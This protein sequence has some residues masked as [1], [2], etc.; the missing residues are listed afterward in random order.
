MN[1]LESGSLLQN[2]RYKVIKVLGQGGFGVTYLA[3]QEIFG[4]QVAIKEFFM[5][6]YCN[7]ESGTQRVVVPTITTRDQVIRFK[8]KFIKEA[9]HIAGLSHPNIVHVID[10]FEENDTA[11]YVMEYLSGGTL[12]EYV[13]KN[14][15]LPEV[16]AVNYIRQIASALG[17]VHAHQLLHLD[18]KPAN[19]MLDDNGHAVLV[20]FGVSKRYDESGS[21][22]SS[23]PLGVS[24]GYAPIEQYEKTSLINFSPSTDIYSLGASLFFLLTGNHPPTASIL[25][26]EGGLSLPPNIS[27][28]L[29]ECIKQCMAPSRKARPQNIEQ[30]MQLLE[31]KPLTTNKSFKKRPSTQKNY[32]KIKTYNELLGYFLKKKRWIVFASSGLVF[33]LVFIFYFV[34]VSKEETTDLGNVKAVEEPVVTLKVTDDSA[35]TKEFAVDGISFEMRYVK[36]GSFMMGATEEQGKET[37]KTEKPVH[38]VIL[39]DFFIAK[40]EVTQELWEAVMGNN[41]SAFKDNKKPVENVSWTDC[42]N[43]IVKLNSLTG[44]NFSLPTEAQWE[45]A[46][47]GGINTKK[48]RYAGDNDLFLVGWCKT[49]S[50]GSTQNVGSMRPNELGLYDM[51]GNVCEWCLDWFDSYSKKNQKNP[52]GPETGKYKVTRGGSWHNSYYVCRISVRTFAGIETK[53]SNLGFRLVLNP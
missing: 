26:S 30:F 43:F 11:Y 42:Q 44:M 22:T 16:V 23:T 35:E 8:E 31:A 47:R 37:Y 34:F 12:S 3:V 53:G 13:R 49:N 28:Q 36:G 6:E 46:A 17:Y 45:Y 9:K 40:T 32:Q 50:K 38:K 5:K 33:L 25:I 2:G 15:A 21:Q 19:I 20:D 10:V 51:T 52:K 18:V 14:G 41:P 1:N 27:S 4:R 7:R 48:F 39:D 29:R 24:E